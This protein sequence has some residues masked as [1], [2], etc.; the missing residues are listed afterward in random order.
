MAVEKLVCVYYR[1]LE[2]VRC[3]ET[4]ACVSLERTDPADI[5]LNY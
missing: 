4:K 2:E 3:G 1:V 5:A